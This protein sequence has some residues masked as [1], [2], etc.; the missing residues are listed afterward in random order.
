MR[1]SIAAF[2]GLLLVL[3]FCAWRVLQPAGSPAGRAEATLRKGVT[4]AA[5]AQARAALRASPL[6]GRSYR[7]LA[8]SALAEHRPVDAAKL[9]ALAGERSPRDL[10]TQAWLVDHALKAGDFSQAATHLD[11]MLRV[12]PEL[13]AKLYPV[14]EGM[15][16]RP[17]SRPAVAQVLLKRPPW[18]VEFVHHLFADSKD[19]VGTFELASSLRHAAGGL[20]ESEL[21][22]FLDRLIRDRQWAAAYLIWVGSLDEESHARIGNVFNGD[23]ELAP[24]MSGFDWRFERIAGARISREQTTG[25][26]GSKALRVAF[27][28]RRVP[29]KNVRQLLVLTPGSYGLSGRSRLEELRTARGLVWTLSC[30]ENGQVLYESDSFS[31]QRGWRSF[32]GQFMVPAAGCGGQWLVLG[33]PARIPA[34]QRIG[35]VAWFDDIQIER[36]A[37]PQNVNAST[38]TDSK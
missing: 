24:S 2:V 17:A 20:D 31:G 35:G 38:M 26:G 32:S 4:S 12:Q 8:E 27:E 22:A 15:V 28:D 5:E 34:E 29:F 9:F 33:L 6:D 14:L 3:T 18:R 36:I 21:N 16:A 25:A 10:Q 11:Q 30:A 7:L 37:S 19:L 13:Q 23:F 1:F